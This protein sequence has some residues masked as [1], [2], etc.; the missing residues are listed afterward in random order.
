MEIGSSR[1][2][3][4]KFVPFTW[5]IHKRLYM[6]PPH[7]ST[8]KQ[9]YH[10]V[11]RQEICRCWPLTFVDVYSP[12]TSHQWHTQ[13][14]QLTLAQHAHSVC[15]H[16][17]YLLGNL[18]A[19]PHHEKLDTLRLLNFLRL[20][21]ATIQSYLYAHFTAKWKLWSRMPTTDLWSLP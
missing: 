1:L 21:S 17:T 16:N 18:G 11:M 10:I 5:N 15:V 14:E 20:F 4:L 12:P 9:V 19:Y 8:Y 6:T 3:K 7:L 13:D 2:D